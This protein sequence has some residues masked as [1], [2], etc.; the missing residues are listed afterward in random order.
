MLKVKAAEFQRNIGKYQDIALIQPVAVTRNGRDGT[1]LI[2]TEEYKR[3]KRGEH[4]RRVM[5]L[6]DFT[7]ED[8]K[9]IENARIAPEAAA[10]ND[11]M[12]D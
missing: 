8:I 6:E 1:V 5:R 4:G 12:E 3:L 7:E 2:S 9:A 11:E 10:F